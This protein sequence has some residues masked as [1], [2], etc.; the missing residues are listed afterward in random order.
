MHLPVASETTLPGAA[1]VL[2]VEFSDYR[3]IAGVA[4]PLDIDMRL[5]PA[6]RRVR[7][8]Y[9]PPTMNATVRDEV[10]TFPVQEQVE[11]LRLD[12]YP[13]GPS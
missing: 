13:G 6:E 9:E 1:Q 11:E 2:R 8:R 3:T 10:F 5:H 4:M 12:R 7:I